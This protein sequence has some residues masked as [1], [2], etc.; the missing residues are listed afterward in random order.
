[1]PVVHLVDKVLAQSTRTVAPFDVTRV[2]IDRGLLLSEETLDG[3]DG[4][5]GY[6][7]FEET[8]TGVSPRTVLGTRGGIFWNTGD[9]HDEYGNITEDPV[10]RQRIME[11][12]MRKEE[13]AD[14]EIPESDKL[15]FYGNPDSE[16]LV[17]SWGSPKGPILEALNLLREDGLDPS[18]LQIRLMSPFPSRTVASKL[19]KAKR[20]VD[21][22]MNYRGQLAALI[23]EKTGYAPTNLILKST[24]RPM[25]CDE[26]YMG[27]KRTLSEN[28]TRVVLTHGA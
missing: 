16:N 18:F 24:G 17:V 27:I 7:R 15:T 14:R 22:E 12:R 10:L 23:R 9:E 21:V 6:K 20:I 11:K 8:E 4:N 28:I 1:M 5:S 25:T 26:V 19:S 2:K 3:R 13:L